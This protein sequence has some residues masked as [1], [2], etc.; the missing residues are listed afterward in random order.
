[1]S[2]RITVRWRVTEEHEATIEVDDDFDLNDLDD[3][4]LAEHEDGESYQFTPDRS[5]VETSEDEDEGLASE[6][7]ARRARG[8]E[9]WT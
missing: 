7:A 6:R 8:Q 2:R 9:G 5:I 4:L 1:M 3:D